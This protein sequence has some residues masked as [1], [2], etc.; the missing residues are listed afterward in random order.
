MWLL[1]ISFIVCAVIN[2]AIHELGHFVSAKIFKLSPELR[3]FRWGI[4]VNYQTCTPFQ[5]RV[6]ATMGFGGQLL[7]G[8]LLIIMN[9]TKIVPIDSG[10]IGIYFI[11]LFAHFTIYP[12][13][14]RDRTSNDFNGMDAD[15]DPKS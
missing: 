12:F 3:I 10:I 8:T 15:E 11:V 14:M 4:E 7:L 13:W 9:A 5:N 1:I 2:L 6:I